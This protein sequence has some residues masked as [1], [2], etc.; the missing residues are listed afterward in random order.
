MLIV[1]DPHSGVPVYRQILEQVRFQVAAGLVAAGAELPSTRV[2]SQELGVN[3][4]TVSKAYAL[5]EGEGVVTR[6]PGLPLVV[7]ARTGEATADARAAELR[8]LLDPA[9]L[10]V[11]QLGLTDEQAMAVFRE[12]L[13]EAGS[14]E[15][16]E[17]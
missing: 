4:M 8:S 2:L 6:R 3:P 12:A 13:A 1:I 17:S 15:A 9:A 10:A 11:R 14:E 16:K 7:S 5:L